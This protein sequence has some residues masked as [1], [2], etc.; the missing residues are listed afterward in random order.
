[1][2]LPGAEPLTPPA[3]ILPLLQPI[4]VHAHRHVGLRLGVLEAGPQALFE[5]GHE[6][7]GGRLVHVVIGEHQV[8]VRGHPVVLSPEAA[9]LRA[10]AG[11]GHAHHDFVVA[12]LAGAVAGIAPEKKV[13]AAAPLGQAGDGAVLQD[14]EAHA[15][16]KGAQLLADSPVQQG[17]VYVIVIA[18][19]EAGFNVVGKAAHDEGLHVQLLQNGADLPAQAQAAHGLVPGHPGQVEVLEAQGQQGL[20]GGAIYGV[21]GGFQEA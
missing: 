20:Y 11:Q 7:L 21:F 1:M 15:P 18:G 19:D 12:Y 17:Q 4:L 3:S 5:H 9:A 6:G 8:L 14:F 16:E 2:V 10:K 13:Q